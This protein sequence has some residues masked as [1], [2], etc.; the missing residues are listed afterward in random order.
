[1]E[2][3]GLLGS[4]ALLIWLALRGVNIVFAAMLCSLLV[5]VTSGLPLAAGLTEYFSFGP[6]GAFTFAGRFFLLF[7]AGAMFGRVMG[8]S[9][10]AAAIALAL[11][12]RPGLRAADLWRCGGVRGDL[13]HVPTGTQAAA[14]SQYPQALILRR[15][16]SRGRH[17]HPYGIAGD[18]VHS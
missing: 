10:A 18:P 17:V 1:M 2:Y 9:H 3:V 6:L 14:G 12:H 4:V 16:C 11:D 13:R 7:A 15:P 8:D 5:I